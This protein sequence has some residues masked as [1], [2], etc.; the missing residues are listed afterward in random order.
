MSAVRR[1]AAARAA[2]GVA[3][4]RRHRV[5]I[6]LC[7][8][9]LVNQFGFGLIT[10]VLP[11]YADSFGLGPSLIGLVIGVYG[12]ARFLVSVPAGRL[13]ETRGRRPVLIG[14][15]LL[16]A[17]ASALI[18]SAANLPQLLL[19]RVLAGAGAATVLVSGQIMVGDLASSANRA[20]LMSI[21]QGFFLVGVGL[22]PAP[23]GLLADH[24]GIRAPFIAYAVF[25]A[26]AG[27]TAMLWIAETRP[28]TAPRPLVARPGAP[29]VAASGWAVAATPAFVLVSA[30]S[31]VQTF[32]RTGALF[33]V[34]PL[35]GSERL[36][37]SATQI[38]LTLTLVSMIQLA[39]IYHA[40]VLS[41]RFGRR[42]VIWP[43]TILSG[44]SMAAFA[45]SGSEGAFFAS[46]LLWG[47][48]SGISGPS[49]AAYVADLAPAELRGRMFGL[50]RACSDAGYIVG[51][52]L[53]GW[54]TARSGFNAPLLLTAAMFI[55]FGVLFALLAPETHQHETQA[56]ETGAAKCAK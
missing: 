30:V 48:A 14:G 24:I 27:V 10:P 3:V 9:I 46:A 23:G 22:G 47:M 31:F 44:V 8:L 16:T 39:V 35:L 52:L 2:A 25:S 38:G 1:S 29:V 32:A 13:A 55:I 12:L 26:L 6:A 51:P 4:V 41:D 49:P 18:A 56:A 40:G 5:F 28:A 43:S 53:L 37:L 7:G 33:N 15:T 34:V 54:L 21:Y 36:G 20:R 45:L 42:P 19:Y 17:L 50:Y 11:L